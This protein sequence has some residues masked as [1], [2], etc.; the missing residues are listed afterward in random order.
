VLLGLSFVLVT[1]FAPKGIGGVDLFDRHGAL[2]RLA[3][4]CCEKEA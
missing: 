2:G 4:G 3:E 1:L